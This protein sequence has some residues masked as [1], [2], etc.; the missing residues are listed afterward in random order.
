MRG[1]AQPTAIA[2]ANAKLP[3]MKTIHLVIADLFLPKEIAA[4]ACAGLHLPALEKMLAR[5]TSTGSARA[6]VSGVSLENELCGLFGMPCGEGMPIAPVCASFDGLGEGCWLRADPVH[7]RLQREQI[8]LL[9]DVAVS[10]DEA[11]RFCAGL[12][13]YFAGQ[14]MAFFAPYPQRWYVRL[15]KLPDVEMVALSQVAGRNIDGLLPG[16]V[17]ATRWRQVFNEIQMLLFAHPLNADR[18]ARGEL[19]VNGVWLWG[20]GQAGRLPPPQKNYDSVSSDEV[21]VE[22]FAAAAGIPFAEWGSSFSLTPPSPQ[23][24]R[25]LLPEGGQL[26]V[27]TGLRSAL[28]RGD[29]AG[30]RDVLQDFETGYAQP[31]WQALRAGE[32]SQL[33]IDVLGGDDRRRVSLTRADAW[34][35]WRRSKGLAGYSMS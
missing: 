4:E 35:F 19:P 10:A 13:E 7:L 25:G 9:P 18:E 17:E 12:N 8:V 3:A 28:R 16:G 15:D 34:A 31:L 21:L 23:G 26:L 33:R 14:G 1:F 24:E 6:D 5:G 30:W 27:F 2:P 32:I 20:V 22:M 29:L 11:G